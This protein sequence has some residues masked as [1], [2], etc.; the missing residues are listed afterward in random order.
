MPK[1]ISMQELCDLLHLSRSRIYQ[2]CSAGEF[3]KPT[4]LHPSRGGRVLWR[5]ETIEAWLAERAPKQTA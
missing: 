4:K 5:A 1:Y 2:L 3:P